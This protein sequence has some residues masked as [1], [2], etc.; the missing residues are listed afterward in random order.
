MARRVQQRHPPRAT[1]PACKAR[2]LPG[3]WW[4]WDPPR[5]FRPFSQQASDAFPNAGGCRSRK[6][7][8]I[9][10]TTPT[11]ITMTTP[12]P[13]CKVSLLEGILRSESGRP[14]EDELGADETVAGGFPMRWTAARALECCREGAILLPAPTYSYLR[15]PLSYQSTLDTVE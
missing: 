13:F 15:P 2:P 1:R 9:F 14:G 11:P 3:G 12:N 7:I 5:R 10:I 4:Q 8:P 6:H